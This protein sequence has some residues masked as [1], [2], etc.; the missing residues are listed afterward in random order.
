MDLKKIIRGLC[1]QK[2][3][4]EQLIASLEGLE[5][6]ALEELLKGP[7]H[8]GRVSMSDEERHAVSERMKKYWA[9]RRGLGKRRGAPDK[10]GN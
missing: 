7:K 1:Q 5:T 4:M 3:A 10:A 9:N 6:A 2:E 8:R